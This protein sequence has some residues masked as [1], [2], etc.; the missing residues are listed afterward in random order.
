MTATASVAEDGSD[1][2]KKEE[3][4]EEDNEERRRR[5]RNIQEEAGRPRIR[6]GV[7]RACRITH[8][9]AAAA[10]VLLH[11]AQ[12]QQAAQNAAVRPLHPRL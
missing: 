9:D 6:S 7:R 4:E 12:E 1:L 10:V 11:A 8:S 3:T 5:R 2:A